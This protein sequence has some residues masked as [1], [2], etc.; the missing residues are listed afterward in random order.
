MEFPIMVT[1]FSSA[2]TG[3]FDY[4]CYLLGYV[5]L[6]VHFAPYETDDQIS[7]SIGKE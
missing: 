7:C 2:E 3:A 1:Y 4:M 5:F 6:L